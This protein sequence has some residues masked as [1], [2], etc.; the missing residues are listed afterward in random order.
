M[1]GGGGGGL[2]ELHA[3]VADDLGGVMAGGGTGVVV[4]EIDV[5]E[6]IAQRGEYDRGGDEAAHGDVVLGAGGEQGVG[7]AGAHGIEGHAVELTVAGIGGEVIHVAGNDDQGLSLQVQLMQCVGHG[8]ELELRDLAD[9]DGQN[10]YVGLDVGEERQNN[11]GGMFLA[12][13][14][15]F[16]GQF[17]D[18]LQQPSASVGVDGDVMIGHVPGVVRSDGPWRAQCGVLGA[19]DDDAFWNGGAAQG[20]GHDPATIN[21]TGMGQHDGLRVDRIR[22]CRAVVV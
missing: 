3:G 11:F 19:D 16:T 8:I 22:R 10:L 17:R 13:G 4:D 18:Q 9:G 20:A 15:R 6:L 5:G 7:I 12:M 21:P 1:W 14:V 2:V